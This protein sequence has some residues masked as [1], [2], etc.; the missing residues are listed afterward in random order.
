MA[1]VKFWEFRAE[2][3]ELKKTCFNDYKCYP[4]CLQ[5]FERKANVPLGVDLDDLKRYITQ[6]VALKITLGHAP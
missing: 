2:D 6:P 1:L 3:K 5:N 4:G